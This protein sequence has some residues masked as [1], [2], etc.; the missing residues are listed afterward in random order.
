MQK[1]DSSTE[2]GGKNRPFD[3]R[4]GR[5]MASV[6]SC[7]A[8]WGEDG[9]NAMLRRVPVIIC[10]VVTFDLLL[11]ISLSVFVG[12]RLPLAEVVATTTLG[13]LVILYYQL[14]WAKVVTKQ[15]E[16]EPGLLDR[17]SMEKMLLLVAGMTLL[18]PGL[19][20]DALAL[21]LMVPWVRRQ[22]ADKCN[23]CR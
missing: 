15:L 2:Y 16:M 17:K 12:W 11:V 22:I 18:I 5:N 20:T 19:V 1:D 8:E 6:Y 10:A 3:A 14:R 7:A 23:L 4:E 13:V 21:V 9:E